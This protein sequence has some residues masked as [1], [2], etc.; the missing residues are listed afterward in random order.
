MKLYGAFTK[1]EEQSD[2]TI[3]V[4]GIASTEVVDSQGDVITADCMKAAIP[5]YMKFGAVREMHSPKSA[6]GTAIEIS[7]D[8]VTGETTFTSHVVDPV[9]VKKVLTGTYKGY[10]LGGSIAKRNDLKKSQID[11]I[12]LT[13]ISL[14]DRPANPQAV[15]TCFKADAL[16]GEMAEQDEPAAEVDAVADPVVDTPA[17][18]AAPA[19]ADLP[20]ET[21]PPSLEKVEPAEVLIKSTV[22][23]SEVT[24]RK[25]D[26]GMFEIVPPAEEVLEK[27]CYTI[28]RLAEL[29]SSLEYFGSSLTYDVTDGSAPT[30]MPAAIRDLAVKLYDQLVLLVGT[31]VTAAKQRIKDAKVKKVDDESELETLRKSLSE[32]IPMSP[33][34]GEFVKVFG[35]T[36]EQP[37]V[38]VIN[39]VVTENLTLSKRVT[40]L[41]AQPAPARAALRALSKGDDI[42]D[43]D[44][45]VEKSDNPLDLVKN[46]HKTGGQVIR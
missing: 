6:A 28:S 34:L 21:D 13:E 15:F 45:V 42:T 2:G 9:A 18:E 22:N 39:K 31:E 1:T 41:E 30:E 14:V 33:E 37:L 3:I 19:I 25:R 26:D 27:G 4:T 11:S 24:L 46:I 40:E 38:D 43:P 36:P 8:D 35:D 12:K 29:C 17:V 5:D 32:S 7:V 44:A 20:P 23:G 16:E 10:S